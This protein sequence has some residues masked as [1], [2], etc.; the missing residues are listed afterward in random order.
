MAI[1]ALSLYSSGAGQ[2]TL[3]SVWGFA[4]AVGSQLWL[5]FP[6]VAFAGGIAVAQ[7]NE[8][9][10]VRALVATTLGLG[11]LA[12]G[13]GAFLVPV[14]EWRADAAV[15]LDIELRYPFGP[16]TPSA[17]LARRAE[18]VGV[19]P[20]DRS[21][22]VD[23]PLLRPANWLLY[24]VHLPVAFTLF[25]LVNALLGLVAGWWTTG[26]SPPKR[27]NTRWGLGLGSALVFYLLS[28][29]GAAWV[30]SDPT[31]SA[32]LGAWLPLVPPLLILLCAAWVARRVDL[33]GSAPLDV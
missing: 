15:G 6:F 8:G 2:E 3:W 23:S 29:G 13:A 20:A 26:L 9:A 27:R 12:Y 17:I 10:V 1:A 31:H 33:H 5:A 21:F 24:T 4:E 7:A 32:L 25:G 22:S 11:G 19:Q 16:H 14:A 28:T 30:R 18:V